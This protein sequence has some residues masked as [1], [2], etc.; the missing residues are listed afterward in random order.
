[1]PSPYTYLTIHLRNKKIKIMCVIFVLFLT[2]ILIFLIYLVVLLTLVVGQ[3][4]FLSKIFII[5][6]VLLGTK[7][8]DFPYF[9]INL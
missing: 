3:F 8:L 1:M 4:Q 2:I 7:T 9:S 6:R 5:I